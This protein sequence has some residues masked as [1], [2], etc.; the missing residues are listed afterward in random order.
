MTPM[1]NLN[2][3]PFVSVDNMMKLVLHLGPERVMTDLATYIEADFRRIENGCR[4]N[5]TGVVRVE[6]DRQADLVAESL[7]QHA[8]C[9]RLAQT[10]H[11]FDG[12]HVGSHLLELFG[13]IH[14]VL[15][16][17]LRPLRVED[18]ACVADRRFTYGIGLLYGFHGD[19]HVGNP[20]ERVEDTKD[21][22]PRGGR[23]SHTELDHV[24]GIVR[25]AH[26]A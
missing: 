26:R 11:V 3:M 22:H 24:V 4:L 20:V 23:F 14:I 9:V 2:I 7:H 12:Q 18:V 16:V 25:I 15:E 6:V 8:G 19:P 5:T 21:I 1:Q 17:V 13:A 10:G